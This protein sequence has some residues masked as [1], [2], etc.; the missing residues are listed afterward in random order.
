MG[1]HADRLMCVSVSEADE[2]ALEKQLGWCFLAFGQQCPAGSAWALARRCARDPKV[3]S[4]AG[5][6]TPSCGVVPVVAGCT[7]NRRLFAFLLDHGETQSE[8][9][10]ASLMGTTRKRGSLSRGG[11]W[12][13]MRSEGSHSERESPSCGQGGEGGPDLILASRNQV[14]LKDPKRDTAKTVGTS[15]HGRRGRAHEMTRISLIW[16]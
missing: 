8:T 10:L 7:R 15:G 1:A 5:V 11:A 16:V 9:R 2:Q 12:R 3:W 14:P 4:R 6:R 13:W